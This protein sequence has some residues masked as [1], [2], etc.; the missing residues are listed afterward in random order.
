MTKP[1]K[2][3]L[4]RS[5][6]ESFP[7]SEYLLSE[8][9]SREFVHLAFL[10]FLKPSSH[11]RRDITNKW[12]KEMVP[13]LKSNTRQELQEAGK[14]LERE[15][16]SK[17]V[18]REA[19]WSDL[20]VAEKER[21]EKK[22][23]FEFLNAAGEKRL[24][25]AAGYLVEETQHDFETFLLST[26]PA[27]PDFVS[28][29]DLRQSMSKLFFWDYLDGPGRMVSLVDEKWVTDHRVEASGDLMAFHNRIIENNG[30][31]AEPLEK[32]HTP[33]GDGKIYMDDTQGLHKKYGFTGSR[34]ANGIVVIRPDSYI[35][36]RVDGAGEQAWKDVQESA[37]S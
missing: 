20:V 12:L 31:I 25:S 36:Y 29:E 27:D 30:A 9:K 21:Q 10:L 11:E 18:E 22:E 16:T 19:F 24:R 37:L 1:K 8:A 6:I 26:D 14:R 35:G 5:T 17:A 13:S 7:G 4:W 34:G 32:L 23:I 28:F 33:L 15:W 2:T 3:P